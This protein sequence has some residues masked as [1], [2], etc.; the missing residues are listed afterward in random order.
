MQQPDETPTGGPEAESPREFGLESAPSGYRNLWVPLVVV[1]FLVVGVLVLVFLFFGAVS[2]K[3]ATPRENLRRIVSGGANESK[4]A[5]A[6]LVAQMVENRHKRQAGEPVSWPLEGDFLAEV[7][8]AWQACANQNVYLRLAVAEVAAEC[9]DPAAFDK[10]SVILRVGDDADADGQ[11]RANAM[12]ALAAGA[13]P[14][15]AAE[16]IP[17]LQHADPLLRQTSAVVLQRYPG[18]ET[19]AALERLLGDGALELRGQAAISLAALGDGRGARVLLEML[20]PSNYEAVRRQDERKYAKAKHVR[21][22][23]LTALGALI[24]LGRPE[25]RPR[26]EALAASD[27]DLEVRDLALRALAAARAP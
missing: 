16:L 25:D 5:A 23:R 18:P 17:F 15:G 4:Q 22:S 13:D 14:R 10:L 3:D 6:S 2:G 9:G 1:P 21:A 19:L 20:E 7:E 27:A 8:A 26:L 12:L 11:A 24:R